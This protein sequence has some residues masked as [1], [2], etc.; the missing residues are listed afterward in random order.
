MFYSKTI[1]QRNKI[2]FAMGRVQIPDES[3]VGL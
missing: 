2:S 1:F 3:S